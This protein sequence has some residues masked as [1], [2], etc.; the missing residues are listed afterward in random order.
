[1]VRILRL[2]RRKRKEPSPVKDELAPR[3]TIFKLEHPDGR[4]DLLCYVGRAM[5]NELF[6]DINPNSKSFGMRVVITDDSEYG[7]WALSQLKRM[8]YLPREKWNNELIKSTEKTKRFL[9][10]E[11]GIMV[12]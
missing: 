10:K 3:G 9:E 2:F 7:E 4:L 5:F 8:G 12:D 11:L 6:V 1:M